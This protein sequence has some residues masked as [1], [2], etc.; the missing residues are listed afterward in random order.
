[1]ED[2]VTFQ[3]IMPFESI[4]IDFIGYFYLSIGIIFLVLFFKIMINKF[5]QGNQKILSK[6]EA[7]FYKLKNLN[8]NSKNQKQVLYHFTLYSKE[9]LNTQDDTKLQKILEEIE[10]YKYHAKNIQIDSTIKQN[11][12]RY[13]D[14]LKL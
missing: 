8:L 1:M 5:K 10:P 9:I 3:E 7:S 11:I 14:E 12:K 4:Q 6:E 2:K 13:I